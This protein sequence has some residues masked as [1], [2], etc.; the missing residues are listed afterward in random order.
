LEQGS[1]IAQHKPAKTK[2]KGKK[3]EKEMRETDR[4]EKK[5]IILREKLKKITSSPLES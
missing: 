2:G 3:G 1:G 5:D 4:K